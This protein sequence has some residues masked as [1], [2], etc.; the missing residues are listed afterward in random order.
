MQLGQDYFAYTL[1]K[2]LPFVCLKLTIPSKAGKELFLKEILLS[3]LRMDT[4]EL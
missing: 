2:D 1:K 4:F 3:D